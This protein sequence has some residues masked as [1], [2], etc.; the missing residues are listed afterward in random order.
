VTAS[1]CTDDRSVTQAGTPPQVGGCNDLWFAEWCCELATASVEA[2]N[3]ILA[4]CAHRLGEHFAADYVAVMGFDLDPERWYC[5]AVW[6]S[7]HAGATTLALRRPLKEQYPWVWS[8]LLAGDVLPVARVSE[9]PAA[10]ETERL[11]WQRL[12]IEMITW[13]P[14]RTNASLVGVV[15]M[16]SRQSGPVGP[17]ES[18]PRLQMLG[19]LLGA[20]QERTH[21]EQDRHAAAVRAD[22]E[23]RRLRDELAHED[24]LRTLGELTA[25][26]VHEISQPLQAIANFVSAARQVV[27]RRPENLA[28]AD[29][30]LQQAGQAT[31]TTATIVQR[32][33]SFAQRHVHERVPTSLAAL[34][35]EA[36]GFLDFDLRQ[37]KMQ[38]RLEWKAV[39]EQV[40]VDR[41]QLLQVLINLLQNACDASAAREPPDR[42]ITVVLSS[43]ELEVRLSVRDRGVGL[44]APISSVFEP[45][46]STKSHGLGLGL[47]IS[48]RIVE[49]QGGQLTAERNSDHGATFHIVL[50]QF[51][52][53][54]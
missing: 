24:R 18:L 6:S 54:P 15:S 5:R 25:G 10:A 9:L 33:R 29:H 42:L 49:E 1:P 14:I 22:A 11:E 47:P 12:G 53:V 44:P 23:Q 45:F 38:V 21:G 32:L 35:H 51:R 4:R 7:P 50:P 19:K 43:T 28:E 48:K 37:K 52:T 26:I 46:M 8:H 39:Q 30:W 41:V 16:A 36:L 13:I 40:L 31:Q 17:S 3:T 27:E 34:V 2:G 20:W